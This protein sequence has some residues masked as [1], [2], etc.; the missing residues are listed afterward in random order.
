M[1][2]KAHPAE[3]ADACCSGHSTHLHQSAHEHA[4]QEK[5]TANDVKRNAL[6][7]MDGAVIDPVCGMRVKLDAGKPSLQ[8]KGDEYHFCA[9]GC[10]NKF[11]ADPYFFLSGNKKNRK[12]PGQKDAK[13]TCPMDPE[14]VQV[15]QGTCPICGMDLVALEGEDDAAPE[16][17]TAAGPGRD[18][19]A[20]RWRA[21]ADRCD[22][23]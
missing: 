22:D 9:Q 12:Q 21:G 2:E 4:V 1:D 10:Q 17:C 5:P 6:V 16:A 15:G 13:F 23:L 19:L 3:A 14:I 11:E 20:T 18:P 7:A 8:Y